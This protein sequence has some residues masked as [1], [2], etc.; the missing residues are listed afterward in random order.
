MGQ[1]FIIRRDDW[2]TCKFVPAAVPAELELGQVEFRVDRFAMTANNITYAQ[3]G[4]MIGYWKFFPAEEEGWGRIPVMG[5][6]DVVRSNHPDVPEGDR[7][8]GFFPMSNHLVIQADRVA[9]EQ[10]FD[11]TPHR[12][13]SAPAYRTYTRTSGDPLHAADREDPHMLL[14]GLF[15]TS[16][17][18]EDFMVDNDLFGAKAF[19]ISSA[20]SK[21]AI[22]LAYMLSEQG[23]GEVIGLTSE[24]N[25]AFV[26]GLGF[27]DRT[28]AYD[29]VRSLAADVPTAFVDH[30]GD[31]EVVSAVHHHLDDSLKYSGVVGMTHWQARRHTGS[32]PGAAPTLFFAPSQI[33]KRNEEWGAEGLQERVGQAWLNFRD[34]SDS[35]LTVVRSFG[36]ESVER[37]YKETLEGRAKP[38]EGHVLSLWERR[39]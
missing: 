38:S 16:F 7:V 29:D 33:Q 27:Y 30:S 3:V 36:P 26:E 6:A 11:V 24:R 9:S 23:R 15:L 12:A 19:V 28:I 4:D 8:F 32:L 31:G 1:D 5:F 2:G 34:S 18:L 21:T 20:S 17:M 10:Y 37:V 13:D 25:V 35:W 22:A 14:W 39:D